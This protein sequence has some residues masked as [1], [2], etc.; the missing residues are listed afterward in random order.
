MPRK[1][2]MLTVIGVLSLRRCMPLAS[3]HFVGGRCLR[4]VD[5]T[6]VMKSFLRVP[7]ELR[8]SITGLR[9]LLITNEIRSKHH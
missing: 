7:P 3:N 8:K 1:D 5:S 9:I 4:L 6:Q 2:W